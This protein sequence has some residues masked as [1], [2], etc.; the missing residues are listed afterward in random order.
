MIGRYAFAAAA[1][2]GLLAVGCASDPMA[3][4]RRDYWNGDYQRAHADLRE[5]DVS[6]L[7]LGD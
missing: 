4:I 1:V 3:G 6:G 5:L 7:D 2:L